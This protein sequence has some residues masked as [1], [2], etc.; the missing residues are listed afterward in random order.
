MHPVEVENALKT[1]T[2]LVDTREQ[3]T[4][5]AR[6]RIASTELPFERRKLDFGDYSAK[7]TVYDGEELDFSNSFAVERKMDLDELAGC[8]THSRARFERE[9]LRAKDKNAKIYLLVENASWDKV[10]SGKY[11]SRM[12]SQALTASMFAWLSRYDCQIIMCDSFTSGRLIREI[13]YREVKE[14]LSKMEVSEL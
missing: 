6:H 4:E 8:Y 10:L 7:V 1:L 2:L 9:F 5:K 12:S 3:D 11:R 13:L 14:R